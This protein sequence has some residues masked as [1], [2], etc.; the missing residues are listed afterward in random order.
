MILIIYAMITVLPIQS[1]NTCLSININEYKV[2]NDIYMIRVCLNREY[3]S[4]I[5]DD[6]VVL[7]VL[8]NK[9]ILF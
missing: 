7:V 3:N 9:I 5:T 1:T 6:S 2:I 8:D 4:K